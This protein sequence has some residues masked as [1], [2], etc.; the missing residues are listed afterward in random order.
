MLCLSAMALLLAITGLGQSWV[1]ALSILNL[2]L[3]SAIMALGLNMQ[4]GYAGLFNVGVMGFAALGGIAATLVSVAPVDAA[5]DVAGAD[6]AWTGITVAGVVLAVI[7]VRRLMN[8][9]RWRVAATAA[10]LLAGWGALNRYFDPAVE[11]IESVDPART[12]YLGGLDLPI[13]LGWPAGGLVAAAAAWLIARV[14]LGLRAD[15]LAIATLGIAEMVIAVIKNEDWLTRGVRSVTGL[16]RPVPYEVGLQR[17]PRFQELAAFL[18]T[19]IQTASTIAVKLCYAGLFTA[20]LAGLLVLAEKALHSPWGRMMRAIRDNETSAA[21]MGKD[22]KAR[23]LEIFVLGAAVIGVAGAM[24]TTLEGQFTPGSYQ[25][26]RFTFLIWVMVIIGGS[27][28]NWGAVLGGFLVWFVWI[29]AEPAGLWL[30]TN[31]VAVTGEGSILADYILDGA[32][33]MRV[34][35][36]GLILLL[37]LRFAPGGVLPAQPRGPSRARRSG[38]PFKV[39]RS[40]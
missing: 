6:L 40:W 27:G 1:V 22:I 16:D 10:V 37:V 12:G 20:V 3:I 15:Y 32:P 11:A 26:L 23:H 24:L 28:N 35:V 18:G 17:S 34:L 7:L 39:G 36:M 30:A 38:S 21:A 2:C 13:V 29:E 8:P 14:A 33:Y 31:L 19:D 4:W 5:W 9:G 25:P